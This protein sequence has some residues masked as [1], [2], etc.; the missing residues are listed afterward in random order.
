M[1]GSQ[2]TPFTKGEKSVIYCP[3][4]CIIKVVPWEIG[5]LRPLVLSLRAHPVPGALVAQNPHR[6]YYE[7][8]AK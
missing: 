6:R 5:E 7:L 8:L 1:R 3:A 2:R 4:A